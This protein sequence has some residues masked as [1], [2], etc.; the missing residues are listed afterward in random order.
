MNWANLT[1]K[2]NIIKNIRLLNDFKNTKKVYCNDLEEFDNIKNIYFTK[3]LYK[4]A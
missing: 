4:M 1:T 3:L 2:Y